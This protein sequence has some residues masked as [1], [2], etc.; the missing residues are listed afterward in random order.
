L[1]QQENPVAPWEFVKQV[2]MRRN[3]VATLNALSPARQF[4]PDR[5]VPELTNLTLMASRLSPAMPSGRTLNSTDFADSVS[6]AGRGNWRTLRPARENFSALVPENGDIQTIPTPS[7]RNVRAQMYRGRD[8]WSIFQVMWITAPTYG[9]EDAVAI[10][11][12]LVSFLEG[13]G[14]RYAM[15][16]NAGVHPT[17]KCEPPDNPQDISMAGYTGSEFDLS[18]CTIAGKFRIFTRTIN[19]ERQ[20]YVAAVFY[21]EKD[22][23]VNRFIK[24]FTITPPTKSGSK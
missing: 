24:S 18:S 9:E 13:F 15:N 14:K 3:P 20:M 16:T 12:S 10:K 5:P 1:W 11:Q 7:D 23:N 8:G 21:L 4:A 2:A 6:S 22:D 17:F 19:D